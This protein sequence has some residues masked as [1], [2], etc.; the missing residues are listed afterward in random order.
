MNV[1]VE[2]WS[3]LYAILKQYFKLIHKIFYKRFVIEGVKNIPKDKT[4][5][6]APNHQNAVMDPLAI[7]FS[8]PYQIVFL[9]RGDTFKKPAVAKIFYNLKILPIFRQRDGKEALKKN[10]EIF[11]ISVNV[12]KHNKPFCLFPEA[13]H[14]PVRRLRI[15]KK[16]IQRIAFQALEETNYNLDIA[17]IP[18]GIYY[19]DKF[20]SLA[21]L[22]IQYGKPIF[23][24]DYIDFYKQNPQKATMALRNEMTKRIKPLMID[25]QNKEHY[26]LIEFLRDFANNIVRKKL[27][28]KKNQKNKF[29]ADKI[30][31]EKIEKAIEQ[32]NQKVLKIKQN[33]EDLINL[34]KDNIKNYDNKI[35]KS[36]TATSL[37]IKSLIYIITFPLFVTG[38]LINFLPYFIIKKVIKKIV[39]DPQFFSTI[40]FGAGAVLYPVYYLIISIFLVIFINNIYLIILLIL[41]MPVSA[42][43]A[44]Y[45]YH[46]IKKFFS[47]LQFTLLNKSI[48]QKIKTKQDTIIKDIT[49][50]VDK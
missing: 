14:N 42:I 25:I 45:Y 49:D 6:F 5:I 29:K 38:F 30:I 22:H 46:Y 3:L 31:I 40:K 33:W 48:K 37:I 41:L 24:K 10:E 17:I 1:K 50:I 8:T 2:K 13:Q 27:N 16:G 43:A 20:N 11:N 7:I 47:D 32:D 12:L 19:D 36:L 34:F 15:L 9:A 23:I 18:T 44:K 39:K 35:Y 28:L 26:H 21:T 4:I